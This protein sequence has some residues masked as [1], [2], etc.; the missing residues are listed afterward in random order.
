[1][2][3]FNSVVVHFVTVKTCIIRIIYMYF[4][5]FINGSNPVFYLILF[6]LTIH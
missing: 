2:I 5:I 6:K 3:I 1:M 4:Y